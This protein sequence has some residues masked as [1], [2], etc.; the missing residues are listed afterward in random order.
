[1]TSLNSISVRSLDVS[2]TASFLAST[3]AV[4]LMTGCGPIGPISGGALKG[5]IG[6]ADTTN[7]S[8]AADVENAQLETRPADPHSVNC[9]FAAVGENLYVPTSMIRG[10]KEPALRSWVAHVAEDPRVRIRLG[11][12]VFD[13]VAVRVEQGREFDQAR[14]ALEAKYEIAAADRDPARVIWIYRLEPRL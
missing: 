14:L 11:N 13:R 7:W 8:F 4:F 1:M 6:A 3:L 9:W 12:S 5:E 10:P 2:R